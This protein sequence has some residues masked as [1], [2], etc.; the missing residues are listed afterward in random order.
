[1]QRPGPPI[2]VGGRGAKRTPELAG[3]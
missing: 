3:R 1:V 2:I